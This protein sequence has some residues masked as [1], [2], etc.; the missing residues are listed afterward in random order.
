MK[1][2]VKYQPHQY[3]ELQTVFLDGCHECGMS[4][5][6]HYWHCESCKVM[7][8]GNIKHNCIK[9]IKSKNINERRY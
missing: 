2:K 7:G 6:D 5:N 1:P 8:N 4:E 9:R 3:V